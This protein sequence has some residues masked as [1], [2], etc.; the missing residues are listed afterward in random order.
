MS[1][2]HDRSDAGD[3]ACKVFR[4]RETEVTFSVK[5]KLKGES[6]CEECMQD[7]VEPAL[8]EIISD[9]TVFDVTPA[10]DKITWINMES[11]EIEYYN[12]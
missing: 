8:R 9:M 6:M 10:S 1:C 3:C 4:E 7:L 12:E 5:V 2:I 11:A